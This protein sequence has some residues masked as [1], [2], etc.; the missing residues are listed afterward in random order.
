MSYVIS[1]H[2]TSM[3][4]SH[5]SSLTSSRPMP[6]TCSIFPRHV[7][8]RLIPCH[9]HAK[10][11]P[12]MSSVFSTH[13]TSMSN[14]PPACLWSSRHMPRPCSTLLSNVEG[15][16]TPCHVHV[17]LQPVVSYGVSL[18]VKSMFKFPPSCRTSS[19]LMPRPCST[20]LTYVLGLL[21]PC[22]AHVQLP[23]VIYQ[24]ISPYAKSMFNSPQ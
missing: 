19:H 6:R 24:V 18:H 21:T 15:H 16:L 7:L 9:V 23:S 17:L 13:S 1:P 11:P 3:L 5:P 12:V 4:N 20:Q 14:S 2:T 10:L 8:R 22:H